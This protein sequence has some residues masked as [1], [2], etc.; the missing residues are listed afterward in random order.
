MQHLHIEAQ[1]NTREPATV[2]R[3]YGGKPMLSVSDRKT[4]VIT[5]DSV[6]QYDAQFGSIVY[7]LQKL[8]ERSSSVSW[9]VMYAATKTSALKADS[10]AQDTLVTA[11]AVVALNI[12]GSFREN[13]AEASGLDELSAILNAVLAALRPMLQVE[14][15]EKVVVAD[16]EVET[17]ILC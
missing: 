4:L 1:R 10:E 2:S 16:P 17:R 14:L 3:D 11:E 12:G 7:P 9:K 8:R 13:H 5:I 15:G 6:A